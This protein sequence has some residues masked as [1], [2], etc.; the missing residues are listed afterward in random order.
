MDSLTNPVL[1]YGGQHYMFSNFS[2]FRVIWRGRDWMTSEHAY[3]AAKFLEPEMQDLI[4]GATS[5][6]DAKKLG[7]KHDDLKRSDWPEVK[8]SIMEEILRAK[9]AQHPFIK[10]RLLETIG[11]DMIE[12]SPKD[13]FWGRGPDHHGENHL[14][15]LWMKLRNE[16][17]LGKYE[18]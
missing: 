6:H 4:A 8:L 11:K 1:F 2:A 7:R 16:L 9:L 14:G 17:T 3:Q 12:D 13:S 10:E 15:Q 18:R 5:A